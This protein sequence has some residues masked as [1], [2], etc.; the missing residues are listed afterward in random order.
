MATHSAVRNKTDK[1][2]RC[3]C[4]KAD[5]NRAYFIGR[6]PS[7]EMKQSV[8]EVEHCCRDEIGQK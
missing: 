2:L 7:T 4:T 3:A 1:K 8:I 6:K 5:S